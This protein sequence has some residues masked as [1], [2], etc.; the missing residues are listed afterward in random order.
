MGVCVDVR[1]STTVKSVSAGGGPSLSPFPGPECPDL[2][3]WACSILVTLFQAG[4]FGHRRGSE[5]GLWLMHTPW[6]LDQGNLNQE[7][8]F[9]T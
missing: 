9:N 7:W 5:P 4:A 6:M 8:L 3:L 1:A 2:P